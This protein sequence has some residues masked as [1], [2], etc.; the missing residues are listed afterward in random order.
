MTRSSSSTPNTGSGNS[1]T[2]TSSASGVCRRKSYLR[3]AHPSRTDHHEPE[4]R[5]VDYRVRDKPDLGRRRR[6]EPGDGGTEQE[7]RVPSMDGTRAEREYDQQQ[8]TGATDPVG[9][10]VRRDREYV[11]RNVGGR[12]SR[13]RQQFHVG[14]RARQ[15]VE[16][17]VTDRTMNARGY[18]HSPATVLCMIHS[19]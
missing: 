3:S 5:D 18:A 15:A 8:E 13:H 2:T 1:S 4:G 6:H 11:R 17:V 14:G 19:P 10:Q 12:G 16:G 9:V 7:E